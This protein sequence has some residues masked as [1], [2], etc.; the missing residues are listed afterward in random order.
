MLPSKTAFALRIAE[1]DQTMKVKVSPTV[2]EEDA[3]AGVGGLAAAPRNPN[4]E[5]KLEYGDNNSVGDRS[6]L[7]VQLEHHGDTGSVGGRSGFSR[8]PTEGSLGA[9]LLKAEI[10][11]QRDFDEYSA[12]GSV[13]LGAEKQAEQLQMIKARTMFEMVEEVTTGSSM[14]RKLIF[15]TNQQADLI[16]SSSTSMQRL[17]DI[18]D[19][20]K[21]KL[22]INLMRSIGFKKY[23]QSFGDWPALTRRDGIGTGSNTVPLGILPGRAPFLSYDDEMDA[24][25]Q[26]DRFMA[27]VL[28]PLAAATNA[29]IICEAIPSCCMLA[30]SL[31]CLL[32][33]SPSPRDMRRSRMPSSA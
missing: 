20:T 18:L 3:A 31:T 13:A 5:A 10:N 8:A 16:S 32:Y 24:V 6:S 2:A 9:Q 14:P 11:A 4:S 12:A 28:I 29:I 1:S 27:E 7:S 19:L 30:A 26:I 33:T 22:V 17:L 21:P 15:L 23:T 25:K